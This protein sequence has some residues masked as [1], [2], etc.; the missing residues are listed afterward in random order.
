MRP[1]IRGIAPRMTTDADIFVIGAGPAG[2]AGG[3]EP[4]HP[5][6]AAATIKASIFRIRNLIV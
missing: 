1:E 6:A 3:R 2:P 4:P 5:I